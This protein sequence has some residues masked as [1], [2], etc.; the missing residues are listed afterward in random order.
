MCTFRP[1]Q[2]R[3]KL[4]RTARANRAAIHTWEHG[5]R[6]GQLFCLIRRVIGYL[7]GMSERTWTFRKINKL[8]TFFIVAFLFDVSILLEMLTVE[9]VNVLIIF[10]LMMLIHVLMQMIMS[11]TNPIQGLTRQCV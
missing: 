8:F 1:T 5:G 7:G 11:L 4:A 2:P 6:A 10:P 3:D 9:L